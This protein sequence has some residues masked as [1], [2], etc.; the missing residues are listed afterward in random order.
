MQ[1]TETRAAGATASDAALAKMR[2]DR[3]VTT[4][5]GVGD[6]IGKHLGNRCTDP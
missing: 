3:Y 5:H 6:E 2:A 4:M 1:H